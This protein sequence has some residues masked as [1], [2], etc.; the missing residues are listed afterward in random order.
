LTVYDDDLTD[1]D[2]V[3]YADVSGEDIDG[4][5]KRPETSVV[6]STSD[7]RSVEMSLSEY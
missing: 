5:V 2:I 3:L 7:G 1:A 6:F 4:L